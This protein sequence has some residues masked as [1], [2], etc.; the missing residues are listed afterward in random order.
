M[1][2]PR[3]GCVFCSDFLYEL[4]I[5]IVAKKPKPGRLAFDAPLFIFVATVWPTMY[6]RLLGAN[7]ELGRTIADTGDADPK[8]SARR[9]ALETL[10]FVAEGLRSYLAE[11][12]GPAE[13]WAVWVAVRASTCGR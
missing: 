7:K 2:C 9:R 8:I 12:P 4:A 11:P 13:N 10:R 6:S 3:N 1:H 5:L